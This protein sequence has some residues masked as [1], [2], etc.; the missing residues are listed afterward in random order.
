MKFMPKLKKQIKKG[1]KE[2][3]KKL[4]KTRKEG[5]SNESKQM[6]LREIKMFA[7]KTADLLE[8]DKRFSQAILKQIKIN[9]EFR[10]LVIKFTARK[11]FS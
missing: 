6:S 5:K 8:K 7:S 10:E 1:K 4:P 2:I 9:Q 3:T 11:F